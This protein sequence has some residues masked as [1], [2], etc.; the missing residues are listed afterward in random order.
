[1]EEI[2]KVTKIKGNGIV[3]CNYLE[4]LMA[5]Y[6]IINKLCEEDKIN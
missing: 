2:K 5:I 3:E 4:R 6:S 1:M